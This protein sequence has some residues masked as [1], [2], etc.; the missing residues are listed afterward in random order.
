MRL[1]KSLRFYQN[2]NNT[3]RSYL[4]DLLLSVYRSGLKSSLL[5]IAW[6]A[7]PVTITAIYLGYYLT[8]GSSVPINTLIYFSIYVFVVGISGYLSKIFIET[9]RLRKEEN[10]QQIFL[11]MIEQSYEFLKLT[12][13]LK[14][15]DI[16]QEKEQEMISLFILSKSHPKDA[17]IYYAMLPHFGRKV[18]RYAQ[19]IQIHQNNG[20]P[21]T[22]YL[23]TTFDAIHTTITQ[24]TTV[25]ELL[26]S[27]ALRK[28]QGDHISLNEGIPRTPGFLTKILNS[29]GQL[30]LFDI[31]DA[32]DII[33]LSLEIISGRRI[34]YFETDTNF[35]NHKVD[36]LFKHIETTCQKIRLKLWLAQG[37][38]EQIYLNSGLL[39]PELSLKTLINIQKDAQHNM[40]LLESAI[41]PI[42]YQTLPLKQR[43]HHYNLHYRFKQTINNTLNLLR[44]L[45]RLKQHWHDLPD[46]PSDI[47]ADEHVRVKLLFIE[48]GNKQRLEIAQALN[49]FVKNH[50]EQSN[51]RD[52]IKRYALQ[53]VKLLTKP[54]NFENPLV[55]YAIE[56]SN[57]ANFSSVEYNYSA[58]QK[59]EL[60]HNLTSTVYTDIPKLK[61]QFRKTLNAQ[62]KKY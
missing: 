38:V 41:T 51:P 32:R 33:I 29:G 2:S 50:A 35:D 21:D 18:A 12:T 14:L 4:N 56:S 22:F 1:F 52:L 17:E 15:E 40:Q 26:Q 3:Y 47:L 6:T 31:D 48:L 49:D 61:R 25:S 19:V 13:N 59:A 55:I 11:S 58:K 36:R 54:L 27:L 16:K 20:Y 23:K 45:D 8:Y 30:S 44:K 5:S 24:N 53:T 39:S 28:I 43:Y 7:G 62:Y 10:A 37:L 42:H 34:Y 46:T 60:T 9:I 57:A